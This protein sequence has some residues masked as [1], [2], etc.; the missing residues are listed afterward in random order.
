LFPRF[1]EDIRSRE[2]PGMV[3]RPCIPIPRRLRQDDPKLQVT[4]GAT[5]E[6]VSTTTKKC[7]KGVH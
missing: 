1:R 3:P 2:E 4:V 7:R 5:Q 6:L